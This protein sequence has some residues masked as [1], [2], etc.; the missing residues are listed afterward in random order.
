MMNMENSVKSENQPLVSVGIPTYNR[1]EGLKR[2][3][4]CITGQTYENLEIIVS[5]N[6][7]SDP[8][9]EAVVKEFQKQDNRIQYFRQTENFGMGYNFKFVLEKAIG[10]YFMWAADDD[11]WDNLYI[12][13]CLNELINK[14][15]CS[16]FTSFYTK[17]RVLNTIKRN[18]VPFLDPQK[19]PFDNIKNYIN[20][21][22]PSFIYGIHKRTKILFVLDDEFFDW[23]DCY[24]TCKIILNGG[25]LS[26]PDKYLYTAGIDTLERP[27]KPFKARKGRIYTYHHFYFKCSKEITCSNKLS[28]RQKLIL[29]YKITT[30]T[31]KLFSSNEKNTRPLH[32]F[33]IEK[34]LKMSKILKKVIRFFQKQ[35]KEKPKKV[36]YAQLGEDIIIDNIFNAIGIEK[37][38]YID[39]GAYDPFYL[40]NTALLYSKGSRGINVEP[41]P[42]LFKKFLKHRRKDI[43]L[44]I[45][46]DS[47]E[48]EKDFYIMNVP[49]LNTFSEEEA[50]SFQ[51]QGNYFIKKVCKIKTLKL[52]TVIKMY[53][54][55]IF[56]DLLSVDTERFEYRILSSINFKDNYP[57]VIC[58]ETV[59]FATSGPQEKVCKVINLLKNNGYIIHSDTYINT[60]FVREELWQN[61]GN[62]EE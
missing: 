42:V 7:S 60:I 52:D 4:E 32:V 37:P 18:T 8:K 21:L 40:S 23:Y 58:C 31:A 20:K 15:V 48:T 38:S 16:V 10:E 43:N 1:P 47:E 56:P 27:P 57:K 55:G 59:K 25:F 12:S 22:T 29:F 11:Q 53:L 46:I 3:L 13:T 6:C 17:N 2:T 41:D 44:N 45:G 28:L 39:I 50:L 33:I 61:R 34:T 26:I 36:S 54:S 24:F 14:K 51:K 9:V 62:I 5:D 49:T 30:V 35:K 19:K